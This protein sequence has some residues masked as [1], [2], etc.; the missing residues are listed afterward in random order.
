MFLQ[1]S[2]R[3]GLQSQYIWERFVNAFPNVLQGSDNYHIS[4]SASEPRDVAPG[5]VMA[6]IIIIKP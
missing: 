6:V 5:M 4:L 1:M 2:D 3:F